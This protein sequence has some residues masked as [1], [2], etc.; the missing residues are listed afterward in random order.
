M[1]LSIDLWS[2]ILQKTTCI[3]TCNKLYEAFPN[4][5]KIELK[6]IYDLHKKSLALKIIIGFHNKLSFYYNSYL[7]K[8]ILFINILAIRSVKK[9]NTPIGKKDCIVII[10]NNGDINFFD[11]ETFDHI[12]MIKLEQSIIE[13]EFHPSKPIMLTVHNDFW[14]SIMK[15]HRFNED[16]SI[17]SNTIDVPEFG[18]KIYNFNQL[19]SEIFIFLAKYLYNPFHRKLYKLYIFNYDTNSMLCYEPINRYLDL[20]NYYMPINFYEDGSFECYKYQNGNYF[21]KF[22]LSNYEIKEIETQIIC[23]SKEIETNLV[24]WNFMR[25]NSDMYFYTN[26]IGDGYIYRQTGNDYKIIYQT[27]NNIS[28]FFIKN[29]YII[30]IEKP[31]V[32]YINLKTLLIEEF[33]IGELVIDF[34]VL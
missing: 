2:N 9:W 5:I 29:G 1:E 7:K 16:G 18:K 3:E 28:R 30:F 23:P 22:I 21:C 24:I 6:N 32:K 11:A 31:Q 10:L 4:N 26:R 13:I 20:N 17:Y 34:Y 14:V 25:I 12:N 15:I 8:E 19:T 27:T 33:K